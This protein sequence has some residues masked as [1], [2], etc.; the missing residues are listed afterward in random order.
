[1]GLREV[2]LNDSGDV[3]ALQHGDRKIENGDRS[4]VLAALDKRERTVGFHNEVV[5]VPTDE[6]DTVKMD[7]GHVE[8]PP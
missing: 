8:S 3:A 6:P 5:A 4:G 1:V 2:R 7:L